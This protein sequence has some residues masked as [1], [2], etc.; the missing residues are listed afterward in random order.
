M[1]KL[2]HVIAQWQQEKPD[3]DTSSMALVGRLLRLSKY[4][5][6]SIIQC[7]K[8]IGLTP[9]EFDVL[10]TLR[11]SGE[12]ASLTPS[13]LTSALLLTSGAMTNR[14]DKLNEKGFIHRKHC[15]QDRR[16]V[17]V[18]L[19]EKGYQL[20]DQALDFHVRVLDD[21][22]KRLSD[23]DKTSVS[24]TLRAWLTTFEDEN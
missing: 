4:I 2:D 24:M 16:S 22:T 6:S 19:T 3:M 9:G 10:A 17:T 5:E 8:K 18:E 23:E 13:E 15:E 1:D 14:L 7:H 20:V 12:I 11:R 21:L